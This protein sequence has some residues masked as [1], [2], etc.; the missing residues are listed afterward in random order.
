M[1][2]NFNQEK[3]I[4]TQLFENVLDIFFRDLQ[5]IAHALSTRDGHSY[6]AAYDTFQ[7][8]HL[9]VDRI[10][11]ARQV[12]ASDVFKRVERVAQPRVRA[13]QLRA[14]PDGLVRRSSSI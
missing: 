3:Y 5:D 14:F 10:L 1:S 13:R 4:E 8:A 7:F 6:G 12:S 11:A 9:S 2:S